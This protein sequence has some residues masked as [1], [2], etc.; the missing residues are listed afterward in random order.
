MAVCRINWPYNRA[1]RYINKASGLPVDDADPAGWMARSFTAKIFETWSGA[2]L[3]TWTTTMDFIVPA[4]GGRIVIRVP[5]YAMATPL[6]PGQF[7]FEIRRTDDGSNA[8][9]L[10]ALITIDPATTS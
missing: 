6:R 5:A 7:P 2:T 4:A 3:A 10:R 9:W 8:V 1:L